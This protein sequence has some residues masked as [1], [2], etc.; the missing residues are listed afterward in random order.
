V[1][2]KFDSIFDIRYS[3]HDFHIT[4]HSS[5]PFVIQS[6]PSHHITSHHI[7]PKKK[8]TVCIPFF[9]ACSKPQDKTIIQIDYAHRITLS[10]A[11]THHHNR[12]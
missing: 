7:T 9:P 5:L 4:L 1:E 3:I 6:N 10:K 12:I 8:E 11:H 2:F